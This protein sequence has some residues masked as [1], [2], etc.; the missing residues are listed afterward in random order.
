MVYFGNIY[1]TD[2]KSNDEQRDIINQQNYEFAT[3]SVSAK[4][5]A[6]CM[7]IIQSQP[8]WTPVWEHFP[9]SNTSKITDKGKRPETGRR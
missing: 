8:V 1:N 3:R 9:E 2:N 5:D 6:E 4:T 7:E